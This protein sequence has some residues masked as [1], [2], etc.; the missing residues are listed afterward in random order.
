MTPLLL[1]RFQILQLDQLQLQHYLEEAALDN[2]LID[3]DAFLAGPPSASASSG[4]S[5]LP[6][7]RHLYNEDDDPMEEVADRHTEPDL[8]SHILSQIDYAYS[9]KQREH[10]RYLA[11]FLDEDGYL[12]PSFSVICREA[13]YSTGELS[14]ALSLLQTLDPPGVGASSLSECLLLQTDPDDHLT[15]T[16]IRDHLNDVAFGDLTAL[17]GL[18]GQRRKD[19]DSSI[20]RIRKLSPRPGAVFTPPTDPVYIRPDIEVSRQEDGSLQASLTQETTYILSPNAS[21]LQLLQSTQDAQIKAYIRNKLDELNQLRR[22][23]ETR[24]QTMLRV[25]E[26]ILTYQERFFRFGPAALEP[27]RMWEAA[28]ILGIHE[29]TVSR[30]VCGKYLSCSQG[31]FPLR[32]FFVRS[33]SDGIS[34]AEARE[35]LRRLISGENREKPYSDEAISRI[36]NTRGIPISR[37]TV[38]KYR[39]ELNIPNA[40]VRARLGV[41]KKIRS[42]GKQQ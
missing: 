19:V 9:G 35:A 31:T 37:R 41:A 14:A 6:L 1:Q 24:N 8:L 28:K 22:N 23:I 42:G 34:I 27:F 17:A 15:R 5:P 39:S 3:L 40:S 25:A 21:Y 4:Q 38:A 11:G 16:L 33:L 30:T 32:Y 36:L 2:P 18:L 26:L 10:L 20:Q 13:P 29:S 7:Q 12:R